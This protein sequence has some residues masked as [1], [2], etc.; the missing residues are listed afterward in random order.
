MFLLMRIVVY[1]VFW[2][3]GEDKF[4]VVEVPP[5]EEPELEEDKGKGKEKEKV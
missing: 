5:F 1:M 2:V 3:T 4:E